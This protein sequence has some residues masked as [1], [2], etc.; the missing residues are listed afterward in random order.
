MKHQHDIAA[1]RLTREDYRKN[2]EDLHAP[3]EGKT[4]AIEASRCFFCHDAPCIQACPTGINIP[5]FIRKIST[6]NLKGAAVDILSENI[7]GGT[8]ARVCPVETLCESACVRNHSEEKPVTIGLLQRHA[9]DWLFD[10]RVQPFTRHA[11]TG[12]RV[13]VV[14]AGPAGMACAHRLAL[15]GHQVKVFEAQP[16]AGGLNEYGLAA[17]KMVDDFAQRELQFILSVGGIEL[18]TGKAL[19][20]D[21]SLKRLRKDFDAVFLGV[22]L[23]GT[24]ALSLE[25][26]LMDGVVDAVDAIAELRQVEDLAKIKVGKRVVVIG[27]GNT[28]I[29]IAVQMK[30]LGAEAVTLVYRRGPDAM[31][32]TWYEQELAKNN[33]VLIRYWAKPEALVGDAQ[34]VSVI[35]FE[36]TRL[37]GAKLVG[38]GDTFE[39]PVDQV[40]KAIGQVLVPAKLGEGTEELQI[41]K[42]RIVVNNR[43]Q[44]SLP[45]VYAGGDCIN[46]GALTVNAVQDGKLAAHAI[47]LDLTG[48]EVP[49]EM[50]RGHNAIDG[51]EIHG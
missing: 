5:S 6:G 1:G 42:G 29:D 48:Q 33:G 19:G 41:G 21:L 49:L 7:M 16:K 8:C 9:T 27:G 46:A 20:R 15:L 39:I 43:R 47:H 4:A 32:A 23:A 3:L 2:F 35:R 11:T 28:A 14:G 26:E 36:Q 44:T 40:F 34:G 37:D 50:R 51:E 17:Y 38:T 22:G 45:G 18:E 13:A 10:A 30:R 25:G 12:K 24:N 31:G